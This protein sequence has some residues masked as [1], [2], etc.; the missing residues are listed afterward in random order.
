[1]EKPSIEQELKEKTLE[2]EL[3]YKFLTKEGLILLGIAIILVAINNTYTRYAA[4]PV[5]LIAFLIPMIKKEY[6]LRKHEKHNK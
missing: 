4:W 1:M 5:L 6:A 3:N 2:P